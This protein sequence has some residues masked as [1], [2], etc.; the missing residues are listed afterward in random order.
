VRALAEAAVPNGT[1]Y[2][3]SLSVD[4]NPGGFGTSPNAMLVMRSTD[5][6]PRGAIPITLKR[7]ENP[8]VLT[9]K[10]TLTADPNDSNFVYAVLEKSTQGS[11]ARS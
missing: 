9:D 6:G 11:G 7:D 3:M 10:N 4:T 8:N 1:A 2:L 5:G